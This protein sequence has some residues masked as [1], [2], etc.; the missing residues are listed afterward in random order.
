MVYF[1]G[2]LDPGLLR[3]RP[4]GEAP[5]KARFFGGVPEGLSRGRL[6]PIATDWTP[7]RFSTRCPAG[8]STATERSFVAGLAERCCAHD[9]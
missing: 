3:R 4:A 7:A 8:M 6:K 1:F 2:I 9:P 5:F